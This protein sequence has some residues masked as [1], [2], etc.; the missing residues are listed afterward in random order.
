[1]K[2]RIRVTRLILWLSLFAFVPPGFAGQAQT[3]RDSKEVRDFKIFAD[4]VQAYVRMQNSLEASLS[5]LKPTTDTA[6]IVEHQHAL[7][8]KLPTRA[9]THIRVISS[10][11]RRL[12]GFAKSFAVYFTDPKAGSRARRSARTIRPRSS[13]VCM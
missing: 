8:G 7:A 3:P 11:T 1:M 13:L 9:A 12:R 10:L 4:R 5:A 2:H 6:Q